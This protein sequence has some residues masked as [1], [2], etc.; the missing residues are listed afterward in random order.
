L[1]GADTRLHAAPVTATS[2]LL[3][4][5]YELTMLDAALKAGI[6]DRPVTFEVF[7]RRLGEGR[8]FGVVGGIGRILDALERFRFGEEELAW[9]RREGL[10]S[11]DCIDWLSTYR[12]SGNI[13][14]YAE[15]DLFTAGSPVMTVEGGFGEAVLLETLVLSILNHDSA[16]ASAAALIV[17]AAGHRPLIEM[18][19]RRV[20]PEAAVA[21]ARAAYLAGFASTSNLEAGRRYGIPTAGTAAHAFTLAFPSEAEAFAAQVAASGPRTTLLVDTYD[22][23]EGI[24]TAI[25]VAG[26]GLDAVRIDSGDLGEEAA[27]AR[28]LLD[29]LGATATRIVVTGDLDDRS[30]ADLADA[31]VDGYGVGTRLVTGL[32]WPTAGFVY[33]LVAVAEKGAVDQHPVAKRS[34]GKATVGGRKWAWRVALDQAPEGALG[35]GVEGPVLADLIRTEPAV[36]EGGRA[37]VH[38]VVEGGEVLG[39]ELLEMARDRCRDALAEL[40]GRVGLVALRD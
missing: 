32:D 35:P 6:A 24:R 19:S 11:A 37:L 18:G 10:V 39:R 22:V 3:T 8:T 36:P 28:R 15:G 26:T 1:P 40:D 2:A 9:L 33:K 17:A 23:Q 4:D 34:P 25:E 5:R 30:I 14:S 20:S 21:A 31:P 29:E 13:D 27:K 16:I 7:S 12:F 38:P